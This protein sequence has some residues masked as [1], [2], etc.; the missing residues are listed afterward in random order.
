MPTYTKTSM[1]VKACSLMTIDRVI[2]C[3]YVTDPCISLNF[4]C[5]TVICSPFYTLTNKLGNVYM[6]L[7]HFSHLFNY[8]Q[9]RKFFGE[10]MLRFFWNFCQKNVFF[11]THLMNYHKNHLNVKGKLLNI[12]FN[13]FSSSINTALLL[14]RYWTWEVLARGSVSGWDTMRVRFQMRP[15]IFFQFV[16]SFQPHH[17]PEVHSDSSRNEYQESSWW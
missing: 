12:L 2:N 8:G 4:R 5:S 11:Y 7:Q 10:K 14:P 3:C 6:V 1:S 13:N 9:K 15:L 17:G 16:Y